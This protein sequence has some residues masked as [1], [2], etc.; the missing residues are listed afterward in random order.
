MRMGID[1]RP[2]SALRT[3]IGRYVYELLKVLHDELPEAE[4]YLYSNKPITLEIASPRIVLPQEPLPPLRRLPGYFWLKLCMPRLC[5][6]DRLDI[7]WGGGTL[8][9]SL[10]GLRRVSTVHDL[11]HLLV[12]ETMP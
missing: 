6:Q 12:P 2:L 4:F 1:G 8:L 11:N 7:F 5:R 3:G 9:P 10:P